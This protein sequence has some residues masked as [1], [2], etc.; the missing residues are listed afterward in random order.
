MNQTTHTNTHLDQALKEAIKAMELSKTQIFDIAE[1]A[2]QE[3]Q[4]A[5][6]ELEKV[7]K[8]AITIIE[9]VDQ[10]ESKYRKTRLRLVEVSRD[11]KRFKEEDIRQAY[12]TANEVQVQLYLAREK[13][14]MLRNRRDELQLRLKNMER[15]IA[16]AENLVTQVG[17]A[18]DYLAGNLSQI[19]Q[20]IETAQN[21]QTLG[22]RIIQ[23]QEEERKRVAREIHD[24][25][26]QSMANVV[27]RAEIAERMLGKHEFDMVK[28]E[29]VDLKE[30]VRN[31]LTEVRKIIFDLRPMA[32]D[33]LGL[34]PT[35]R[36]YL[37]DLGERA[38]LQTELLTFGKETRLTSTLEV[39]VFRLVQ[40]AI[41]N[42][43]KHANARRAAVKIE[44][45]QQRVNILIKDDGVGMDNVKIDPH[46]HNKHQFGM[47]GMK[48]RVDLLEGKMEINSSRGEGTR[49]LFTIPLKEEV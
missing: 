37:T 33:D 10:L 7:A 41:T 30:L 25:P 23:A 4:T 2:R 42:V 26:A 27:L 24:G 20:M 14:L 38:E 18:L 46:T 15:T 47:L 12:E 35:L 34:V 40:E 39:A 9:K 16:K 32:L 22:L 48:E 5:K 13:E 45:A 44:F 19:G 11:F 28:Q 49:I 6:K 29:L 3:Y 43:V 8:D 17:V 21:R 31:S 1:N 36:K